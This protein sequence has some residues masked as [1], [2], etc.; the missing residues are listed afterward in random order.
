LSSPAWLARGVGPGLL[1]SGPVSCGARGRKTAVPAHTLHF[2]ARSSLQTGYAGP[3]PRPRRCCM[4]LRLYLWHVR[5]SLASPWRLTPHTPHQH[6]SKNRTTTSRQTPRKELERRGALERL[7]RRRLLHR[8]QRN[9]MFVWRCRIRADP[10][11]HCALWSCCVT[12]Q[13]PQRQRSRPPWQRPQRQ[14][15]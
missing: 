11:R 3:R 12:N 15:T 2:R 5:T 13:R 7:S 10:E 1:L 9:M 14:R 4:L 6:I 8:A